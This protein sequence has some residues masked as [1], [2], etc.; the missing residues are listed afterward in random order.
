MR[1]SRRSVEG[2]EK[3]VADVFGESQELSL[4]PGEGRREV[5][6]DIGG[7]D[8]CTE[9]TTQDTDVGFKDR[10]DDV[11]VEGDMMRD[12]SDSV[13]EFSQVV[14]DEER[15][16]RVDESEREVTQ[17]IVQISPTHLLISVSP[18]AR[19][20][21]QLVCWECILHVAVVPVD[22]HLSGLVSEGEREGEGEGGRERES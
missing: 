13:V 8:M 14:E 22:E 15:V 17:C 20:R 9:E 7:K 12:E 4:V 19:Q 16:E 10:D 11:R 21:H 5:V 6:L 18:L 1:D 3:P 2:R